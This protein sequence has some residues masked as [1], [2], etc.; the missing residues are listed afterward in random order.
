MLELLLSDTLE[1]PL[2]SSANADFGNIYTFVG[3]QDFT[4]GTKAGKAVSIAFQ[5]DKSTLPEGFTYFETG[6]KKKPGV[7]CNY[8]VQPGVYPTLG[9]DLYKYFGENIPHF[10]KIDQE[11]WKS[12]EL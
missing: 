8:A 1:Y 4:L 2:S 11:L 3:R 7:T 12:T 9:S 10:M 6:S 5:Y